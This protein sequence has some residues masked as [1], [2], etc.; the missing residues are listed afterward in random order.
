MAVARIPHARGEVGR[1]RRDRALLD[2]R[3][4]TRPN[5][6]SGP[7]SRVDVRLRPGVVGL[8]ETV[9]AVGRDRDG[10]DTSITEDVGYGVDRGEALAV[11]LAPRGG[12]RS[13]S[14]SR[15]ARRYRR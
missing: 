3:G 6:L 9:L 8:E 14:S 11:G 12:S 10:L 15:R 1:Q 13:S 7:Q 4:Q 5:G 2:A